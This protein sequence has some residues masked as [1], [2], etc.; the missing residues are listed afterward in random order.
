MTGRPTSSLALLSAT[1]LALVLPFSVSAAESVPA[2]ELRVQPAGITL[3]Q[4]RQAHS[5]L[6]GATTPDGVTL[7]LTAGANFASADEKVAVVDSFGWVRPVAS[8]K[9][10]ITVQAA[11]KTATVPVTVTLPAAPPPISFRH[12]VL[13]VFSK[14]GC[15]S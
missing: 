5:L 11:G 7:D 13:P 2:G 15:N 9:T 4:A 3:Q 6:V 12:E 14:G 10:Q 1:A 8:G